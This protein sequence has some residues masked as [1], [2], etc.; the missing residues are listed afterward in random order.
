MIVLAQATALAVLGLAVVGLP[1]FLGGTSV[2]PRLL[3]DYAAAWA[4]LVWA[5]R[6]RPSWALVTAALVVMLLLIQCIP[7]PGDALRVLAPAAWR[8]WSAAG[9]FQNASTAYLSM[10]PGTTV[11]AGARLLLAIL[12]ASAVADLATNLKFRKYLVGSIALSGTLIWCLGTA[13]PAPVGSEKALLGLV[14]LAGEEQS[15]LTFSRLPVQGAGFG[16]VQVLNAGDD[17]LTVVKWGVADGIGSYIVSNHFACG[18]YLTIPMIAV[19][20]VR[21]RHRW[22]VPGLWQCLAAL[23]W[24]GALSATIFLA[25]SRAGSLAMLFGFATWLYLV[26]TSRRWLW[27]IAMGSIFALGLGAM[28]LVVGLGQRVP[29]DGL[30]IIAKKI[31]AVAADP[32]G[33]AVA[34]AS[35]LISNSPIF[36]VGLGAYGSF[37]ATSPPHEMVWAFA[38]NDYAQ[39]LAEAGVVGFAGAAVV[40]MLVVLRL[41]IAWAAAAHNDR[42]VQ[43]AAL[44]G[45][46]G[47]ALHSG[48][49]WNLHVPANTLIASIL[50]GI[51]MGRSP[52]GS[53]APAPRLGSENGRTAGC[54]FAIAGCAAVAG[55][56]AT[57]AAFEDNA[58]VRLRTAIMAARNM[59]N[60]PAAIHDLAEMRQWVSYASSIDSWRAAN[61]PLAIAI[62]HAHLIIAAEAESPAARAA[63]EGTARLW[64]GRARRL[65]PWR[66]E[67]RASTPVAT[68]GR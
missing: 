6:A 58:A 52:R 3:G 2:W 4:V 66:A 12:T 19:L 5:M 7:I 45:L 61:A 27:G 23:G 43:A 9:R 8:G 31:N 30:P 24:L 16:Y 44:S 50:L 42:L 13:F 18:L 49:D 20:L 57:L 41:R 15:W 40:V 32:R 35:E 25:T 29:R 60:D 67:V 54:R 65:S 53:A 56:I 17:E 10:D 11:V 62:A 14:P 48:F 46:A 59:Q 34:L 37:T 1:L 36:G 28:V 68:A 22:P 64:L 39:F 55:W 38:H 63:E 21:M 26:D 47:L 33:K 51:A